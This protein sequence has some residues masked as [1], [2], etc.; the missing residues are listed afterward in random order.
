MKATIQTD[1]EKEIIRRL[2]DAENRDDIILDLCESQGMDWKDA[3]SLVNSIQETHQL[4]ITMAQSP[5]LTALAVITFLGGAGLLVYV[6]HNLNFMYE[7]FYS[8]QEQMAQY[9]IFGWKWRVIYD[10]LIYLVISAEQYLGLMFLAIAMIL[11]SLRGM[12]DIWEVIF[13]KLGLF[14]KNY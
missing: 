13:N 4:D 5:I 8:G 1:I 14:Q 12:Q 6:I 10:F 11:G 9:E 7:A 2:E 3:E